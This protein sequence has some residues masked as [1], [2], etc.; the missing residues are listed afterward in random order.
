MRKAE[1]ETMTFCPDQYSGNLD[2]MWQ[3]I[4]KF[5]QIILKN[6][7]L[8]TVRREDFDIIVIDYQHDDINGQNAWGCDQPVWLTCEEQ[9][10]IFDQRAMQSD[11]KMEN[12]ED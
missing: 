8:C 10:Q 3:D 7:N 5:I 12:P 9:D 2:A 1:Y 6:E 11:T 4:S